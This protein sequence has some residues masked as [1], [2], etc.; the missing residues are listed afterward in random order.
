MNVKELHQQTIRRLIQT[1]VNRT[2]LNLERRGL[3]T[4]GLTVDWTGIRSLNREI[5]LLFTHG[6]A[7]QREEHTINNLIV[8]VQTR[9][10]TTYQGISNIEEFEQALAEGIQ[11]YSQHI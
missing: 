4:E 5:D 2:H 9:A 10:P 8:E 1:T 11:A 6:I 3:I 7:L